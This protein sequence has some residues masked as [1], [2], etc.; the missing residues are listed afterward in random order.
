MHG[1][2]V[3]PRSRQSFL[4]KSFPSMGMYVNLSMSIGSLHFST[5][6]G[7]MHLFLVCFLLRLAICSSSMQNL[8]L[9]KALDSTTTVILLAPIHKVMLS[10]IVM[11]ATKS[12]WC[13]QT[14][15]PSSSSGFLIFSTVISSSSSANERN[16]SY[17]SSP[18]YNKVEEIINLSKSLTIV[19]CFQFFYFI[20][21]SF[22]LCLSIVRSQQNN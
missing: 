1:A 20:M 7:T 4:K 6:T 9:S 14:S 12:R 18:E 3:L 2:S 16:T 13:Q 15:Y 21:F 5:S 11:P 19:Q 10:L 8:L 17:L 22:N